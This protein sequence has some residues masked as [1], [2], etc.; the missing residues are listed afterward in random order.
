MNNT[1]R[2]ILL[3]TATAICVAAQVNV[4]MNR[5]DQFT[6]GA[7][8]RETLLNSA[9]VKAATFGKLY[10][11]YVDGSVYAQPLYL[12][13]VQIPGKGTRN[14]LYVATMNDKVYAFDA[15]RSGPPLWMRNFTNEMSEITPVPITDVTNNNNLNVVGNVGIESTPVIDEASGSMYLVARTKESGHYVQRLHKLDVKDGGDQVPAVV[16]RG[17]VKGS[18]PDAV[19]GFVHFDPRAGNQRPALALVHGIVVIAWA[20]HE[21]LRPYH[22]WVMAYDAQSLTQMGVLCTTPDTADGGIWQSGRAPVVDSNGGIYFEIGN[23]GWDGQRNFGNSVVKLEFHRQGFAVD[24]YYTP[25][26][27]KDLNAR[28]ADVGSTGPLLIPGSSILIC[29]NKNGVI[30]LLDSRHLGHMTPSNDGILQA[31]E[32]NAGRVMAGPAL[33]DG[34]DGPTLLIWCETGVPAAFRFNGRL[35]Q[36]TPY[37]KGTI[38]SHGSPG[39]AL[40]V[41][42]DGTK[43]GTGILWATVTNGRSADHGNAAG[44]LHAFNAENLQELWNSEQVSKRDRLG[45][46]VKF[47]PPVVA[48]GKVYVPDY[49]NAV[50]V[51]GL[52]AVAQEGSLANTRE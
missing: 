3:Q 16:I 44:V 29:G 26:T 40:T 49:D 48:A 37:V 31:L 38:G 47:V 22:G 7:T 32:L 19:K 21:D 8:S 36:S 50:K 25:A 24:D 15:D 27:Y 1:L 39:G 20:S 41:S 28:D 35:L 46:L 23:G 9:N 14:V 17:A 30:F 4:V 13:G 33:W 11:Y 51:Y 10:S 52:L 18:A 45:T 5:Y 12:H 43:S 42:S 34:P 2:L 6:T